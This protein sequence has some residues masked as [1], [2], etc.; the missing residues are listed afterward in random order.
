LIK[1]V[2]FMKT[3][4]NNSISTGMGW[5]I[6]VTILT[7]FGAVIGIILWLFFYAENFNVYQNIAILVVILIGFVAVMGASWASWGMK[8]AARRN[9]K[10]GTQSCS[11]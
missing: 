11:D 1:E 5:R 10:N 6:S 3:E 2:Y 9:E 8:Q 7:F 4:E